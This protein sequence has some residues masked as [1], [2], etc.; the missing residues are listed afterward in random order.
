MKHVNT[1]VS[2]IRCFKDG[3]LMRCDEVWGSKVEGEAKEMPRSEMRQE[4]Q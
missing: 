3:V 4:K 1:V 2:N